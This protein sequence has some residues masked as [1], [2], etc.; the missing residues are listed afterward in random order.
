MKKKEQAKICVRGGTPAAPGPSS[1]QQ[2]FPGGNFARIWRWENAPAQNPPEAIPQS[3]QLDPA[4]QSPI[5]R[6]RTVD[7]DPETQRPNVEHTLPE[8]HI[9][10]ALLKR[11]MRLRQ[12]PLPPPVRSKPLL[13]SL[14]PGSHTPKGSHPP[15]HKRPSGFPTAAEEPSAL[16]V[17]DPL[18]SPPRQD[19]RRPARASLPLRRLLLTAPI[20]RLSLGKL[21]LPA[22]SQGTRKG[23]C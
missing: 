14:P 12:P 17:E 10:L 16:P 20:P 1:G 7:P 8:R 19:R 15:R 23:L 4:L 18:K 3:V 2:L 11:Q 9:P 13:R 5:P 21:R 6:H 22:A